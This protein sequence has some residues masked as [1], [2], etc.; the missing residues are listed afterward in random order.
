MAFFPPIFPGFNQE[1]R[2]RSKGT[3]AMVSENPLRAS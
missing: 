1:S 2:T 3:L